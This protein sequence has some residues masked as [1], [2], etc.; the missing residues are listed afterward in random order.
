[1]LNKSSP[2]LAV[3]GLGYVGL[4]LAVEFGKHFKVV[5]FDINT[6]RLDELRAGNDR[7]LEIDAA[8]LKTA[9]NLVF[10]NQLDDLRGT[11]FFIVTVPTP[12]D[13]YNR[14]DLTPL[15]KA[16][17]TVGKALQPGAVVIYESTVYPRMHGRGLRSGSGEIQRPE[18]QPRLLLR[19]QPRTD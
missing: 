7:T 19:L 2:K 12:T 4:P 16:S 9:S 1:M 11:D 13:N 10:S 8:N 5:G 17:E 14:P 6:R 18:I 15:I 3:I